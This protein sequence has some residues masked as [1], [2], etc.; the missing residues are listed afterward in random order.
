MGSMPTPQL[1]PRIWAP[2]AA[3][4][5]TARGMSTPMMVKNPFGVTS[6]VM[7]AATG[8]PGAAARAAATARTASARSVMVSTTIRSTPAAASAASCRANA[9]ATAAGGV[10]PYGWSIRPVGPQEAAT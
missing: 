8:T 6:K 5:R 2:A 4:S 10:S 9:A 1:E 7:V 3:S